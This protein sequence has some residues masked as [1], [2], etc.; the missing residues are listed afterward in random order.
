M[1]S[2]L[3]D[4][5]DIIFGLK[6]PLYLLCWFA[7][8]ILCVTRGER[9][10]IPIEMVIYSLLMVTIPLIS[11]WNYYVIDGSD[12][13]EGF[14]LLKAYLFISMAMLLYVT[15]TNLL[16]YLS[17]ALTLLALSILGRDRIGLH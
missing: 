12:P 7:G 15:G 16:K 14:Q 5:A 9:V 8:V 1:L 4:P 6:L 17:I 10:R 3:F 2:T 13:F 11:I